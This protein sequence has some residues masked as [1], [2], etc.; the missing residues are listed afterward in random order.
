MGPLELPSAVE[1][2]VAGVVDCG[3][4]LLATLL[5]PPATVFGAQVGVQVEY[6][7]VPE[8]EVPLRAGSYWKE[9]VAGRKCGD[10]LS[11]FSSL[12]DVMPG[13]SR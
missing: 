13:G 7:A 11:S 6:E 8:T 10:M 12:V 1:E 4:E 2:D 3:V 5:E 9:D